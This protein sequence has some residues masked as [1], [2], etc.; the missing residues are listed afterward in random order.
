MH[1]YICVSDS[2]GNYSFGAKEERKVFTLVE[3]HL[4]HYHHGEDSQMS[5]TIWERRIESFRINNQQSAQITAHGE[6]NH[7]LSTLV[8][9]TSSWSWVRCVL[10]CVHVWESEWETQQATDWEKQRETMLGKVSPNKYWLLNLSDP[11]TN[12]L[13]TTWCCTQ[14]HFVEFPLHFLSPCSF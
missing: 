13:L 4:H 8:I 5:T 11:T 12:S 7:N 10:V 6:K 14:T 3:K 2:Q 9:R 1:I